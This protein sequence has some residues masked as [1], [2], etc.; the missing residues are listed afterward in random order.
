MVCVRERST[1]ARVRGGALGT[2]PHRSLPFSA[3]F[4][5][6]SH[7]KLPFPF[8]IFRLPKPPP[9]C[10]AAAYA[11]KPHATR[12]SGAGAGCVVPRR[13]SCCQRELVANRQPRA[14]LASVFAQSPLCAR[15]TSFGPSH[16]IHSAELRTWANGRVG[17]E[18]LPSASV[19]STAPGRCSSDTPLLMR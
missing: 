12:L 11:D 15:G 18:T 3:T 9:I 7:S 10:A 14:L 4:N 19:A 8:L 2:Q 16:A 17:S 5:L 1:G 13:R 6:I